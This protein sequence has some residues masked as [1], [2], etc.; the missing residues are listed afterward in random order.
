MIQI[1]F[2]LRTEHTLTL[3]LNIKIVS[4]KFAYFNM[5]EKYFCLHCMKVAFRCMKVV[6]QFTK[7]QTGHANVPA[8]GTEVH[9][10]VII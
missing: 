10:L 9:V 2:Y 4:A 1:P 3:S 7:S 8:D 5:S 6:F